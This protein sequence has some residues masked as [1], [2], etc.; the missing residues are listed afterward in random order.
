MKLI[1]TLIDTELN[2]M[3]SKHSKTTL[4]KDWIPE[5]RKVKNNNSRML[6][7]ICLHILS[8]DPSH[9]QLRKVFDLTYDQNF[10]GVLSYWMINFNMSFDQA[11]DQISTKEEKRS[12]K[13]KQIL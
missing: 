9:N 1:E 6:Q 5:V 12:I 13:L 7:D 11:L 2:E 3:L 10:A 8:R 4:L